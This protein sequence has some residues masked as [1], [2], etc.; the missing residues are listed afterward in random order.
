MQESATSHCHSTYLNLC[1]IVGEIFL[2]NGL[3]REQVTF[4]RLSRIA[5]IKTVETP[6]ADMTRYMALSLEVCTLY[7][8]SHSAYPF[9]LWL[10]C[11]GWV[12]RY[13]LFRWFVCDLQ[14]GS[15]NSWS[16]LVNFPDY[17]TLVG[18]QILLAFN[19]QVQIWM[20]IPP[21]FSINTCATF[22]WFIMVLIFY[23]FSFLLYFF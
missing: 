2:Q 18:S 11:C 1:V 15:V 8:P 22:L 4:N 9:S 16:E 23:L 5:V 6:I 20:W 21:Y 10:F 3:T 7:M 12:E 13:P 14:A 17:I 19:S